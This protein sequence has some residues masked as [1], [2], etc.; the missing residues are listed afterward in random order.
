MHVSYDLTKVRQDIDFSSTFPFEAEDYLSTTAKTKQPTW[1]QGIT[2]F[3]E[4]C[5][6]KKQLL[7]TCFD[8]VMGYEPGSN[9]KTA[10]A[11]PAFINLFRQSIGLKT[12]ADI[13]ISIKEDTAKWVVHDPFWNMN[14]H[15]PNQIGILI[16]R[17]WVLKFSSCFTWITSED[18]SYQYTDP[19]IINDVPYRVIPGSIVQPKGKGSQFHMPVLFSR[20]P[21]DYVIP[22]GTTIAYLTF[23]R[24]IRTVKRTDLSKQ[25]KEYIYQ[26]VVKND[27]KYMLRK[28]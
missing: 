12:T 4:G 22:K 10:K 26:T 15:T 11:C 14:S 24:P 3:I 21:R 2:Q 25:V 7:D 19:S 28:K 13:Y 1:F 6:N 8:K 20:E 16:D 18:T 23:D 27:V 9:L 5:N 17:Y